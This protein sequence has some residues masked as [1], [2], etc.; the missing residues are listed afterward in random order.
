MK[1]HISKSQQD[2][3]KLWHMACAHWYIG[4]FALPLAIAIIGIMVVMAAGWLP[5]ELPSS[6]GEFTVL[7]LVALVF[8]V[9]TF[10][11]STYVSA[12]IVNKRYRVEDS[13]QLSKLA[14]IYT[15]SAG[16]AVT[17]L[18][19]WWAAMLFDEPLGDV[20][21]GLTLFSNADPADLLMYIAGDTG[22]FFLVGAVVFYLLSHKLISAGDKDLESTEDDTATDTDKENLDSDD[23]DDEEEFE[24]EDSSEEE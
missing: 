2:H 20:D 6:F 14:T 9:A 13:D 24:E 17:M 10:A 4:G 19:T 12:R 3:R 22:A 15:V 21:E 8:Y 16:A 7:A 18:V 5:S 23:D 1:D 11:V